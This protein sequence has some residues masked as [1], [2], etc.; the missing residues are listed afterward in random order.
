MYEL[1]ARC[2]NALDLDAYART[3]RNYVH[4]LTSTSRAALAG[5]RPRTRSRLMQR[6]GYAPRTLL[7][8]TLPRTLCA[9]SGN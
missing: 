9:E 2:C 4:L 8:L 1:L 3:Q 6:H 7:P 5:V